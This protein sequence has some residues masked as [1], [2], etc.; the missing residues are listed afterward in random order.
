M[1]EGECE[2]IKIWNMFKFKLLPPEKR[3]LL[4]YYVFMRTTR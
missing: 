3:Q 2:K 4:T 1:R